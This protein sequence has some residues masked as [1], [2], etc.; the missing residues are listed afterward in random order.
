MIIFEPCDQRTSNLIT[1]ITPPLTFPPLPPSHL[2]TR[3]HSSYLHLPPA[4]GGEVTRGDY[5]DYEGTN[6]DNSQYTLDL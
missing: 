3:G 6:Q 5:G 2:V 4:P 1:K